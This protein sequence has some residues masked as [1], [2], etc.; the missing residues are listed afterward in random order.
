[1]ISIT[2]SADNSRELAFKINE[3][4]GNVAPAIAQPPPNVVVHDETSVVEPPKKRGRKPG[5]AREEAI[6][7]LEATKEIAPPT[8]A[9]IFDEPPPTPQVP[10]KKVTKQDVLN[11]FQKLM[12]L[13]DKAKGS[14]AS[15]G[16]STPG[17][18]K[19]RAILN[20]FGVSGISKLDEKRYHEI[21]A[22]VEQELAI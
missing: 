15:P 20:E 10:A 17:V 2:F 1:M 21:I 3:Y 6:A 13:E 4:V 19:C 9:T 22:R 11:V 14:T 7:N 8:P 18:L 12:E 16:D 5:S